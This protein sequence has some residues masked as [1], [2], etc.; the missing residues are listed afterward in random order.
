M[1]LAVW[2]AKGNVRASGA[3]SFLKIKKTVLI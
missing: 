1:L 2:R 3:G